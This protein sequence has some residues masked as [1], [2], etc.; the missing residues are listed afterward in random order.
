MNPLR[1]R[2]AFLLAAACGA[3]QLCAQGLGLDEAVRLT[4]ER[5]PRIAQA[6][7]AVSASEGS[8]RA[9][10]G[11]Y[12]TLFSV[13]PSFRQGEGELEPGS[14]S[15][16]DR[17]RL[18]L[19]T[20]Q[21][22]FLTVR[23]RYR[24][25]I[26]RQ[27]FGVP[28][29]PGGFTV[30]SIGNLVDSD[31]PELQ[32]PICAP[33]R[34]DPAGAQDPTE[35]AGRVEDFLL[36]RPSFGTNPGELE[37]RLAE[38]LDIDVERESAALRQLSIELLEQG[39]RLTEEARARS[40]QALDRIG[41]YP[42][43]EIRR[44][45]GLEFGLQRPTPLGAVFQAR[46]QLQAAEHTY[47][48]RPSDPSFGGTPTQN[49]WRVGS[50]LAANLPLGK[51]RG[52]VAAE[53]PRRA[54]RANLEAARFD[55]RHA[56]A[57]QALATTTAYLDL[58][59]AQESQVLLE[60]SVEENRKL[61]GAT[62]DLVKAGEMARTEVSRAAARLADAQRNALSGRESLIG[63]RVRLAAAIGLRA[64]ELARATVDARF[65]DSVAEADLDQLARDFRTRRADV[66][67][68]EARRDS[69]QAL[70]E[71]A[72]ADRRRRLDLSIQLT[73][74][75]DHFG[76]FFWVLPDEHRIDSLNPKGLSAIDFYEPRGF[77]RA[78]NDRWK[79]GF[80]V[81]LT[82]DL[83]FG[84]NA[85]EGRFAQSKARADQSEVR[86]RDLG[87]V[88]DDNLAQRIG[89]LRR[90]RAELERRS[91]AIAAHETK[92]GA[93]LEM[94]RV[95]ELSLLDTIVSEQDLTQSRLQLV[96]ARRDYALLLAELRFEA[97]SL[98]AAAGDEPGGA[99]VGDLVVSAR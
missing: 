8:L 55:L 76:P 17:R 16:E 15:F 51:G 86:L 48:N 43:T 68:A 95:G 88:I 10:S 36:P 33:I 20:S 25:N 73:Y 40:A 30:I 19:A 11:A 93:S 12:D 80:A 1:R 74:G 23:D 67:S 3:P 60:A 57:S 96:R 35:F 53:A 27:R 42:K 56:W 70:F 77:W 38:I 94:R 59:A 37:A 69:A 63:A 28:I 47:R 6:R 90:V 87:R 78:V 21:E 52:R 49:T 66:R 50:T 31:S 54:A 64:D 91:A 24:E 92:W 82:F 89:A 45:L 14:R 29:C 2:T 9:T 39:Y 46:V 97:G 41:A 61:L 58:V 85:A 72:R 18:L 26:T 4:F 71:G 13:R 81:G 5:S 22:S 44:T 84:N 62:E 75:A 7:A 32:Q 83:P 34:L 79:P 98:V 65:P 99:L